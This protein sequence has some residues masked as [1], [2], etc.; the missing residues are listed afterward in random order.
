MTHGRTW[1]LRCQSSSTMHSPFRISGNRG[2]G[3][4]GPGTSH[5]PS[6]PGGPHICMHLDLRPGGWS[7]LT[8]HAGFQS[9]DLCQE[10]PSRLGDHLGRRVGQIRSQVLAF[11]F[12]CAA[13]RHCGGKQQILESPEPPRCREQD[14]AINDFSFSVCLTD[15]ASPYVHPVEPDNV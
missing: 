3:P 4:F 1:E 10:L 9:R 6:S 15:S 13:R 14:R 11:L 5:L 7:F 2:S 12:C 8:P